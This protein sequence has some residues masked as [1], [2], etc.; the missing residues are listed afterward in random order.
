MAKRRFLYSTTGDEITI[1]GYRAL[2]S[3]ECTTIMIAK[4]AVTSG[5]G[6]SFAR[7]EGMVLGVEWYWIE[8]IFGVALQSCVIYS[9]PFVDHTLW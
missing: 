3:A 8:I 6:S 1:C 9:N 7:L 5:L 2:T 4:L